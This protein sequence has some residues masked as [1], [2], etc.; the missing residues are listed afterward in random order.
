VSEL[1]TFEQLIESSAFVSETD[2]PFTYLVLS[3]D[4]A[5]DGPNTVELRG[6]GAIFV[7][8]EGA[9]RLYL[10]VK[11]NKEVRMRIHASNWGYFGGVSDYAKNAFDIDESR[12]LATNPFGSNASS[13][14]I[15]MRGGSM[16]GV[17]V[18]SKGDRGYWDKDGTTF[19]RETLQRNITQPNETWYDDGMFLSLTAPY[20]DH[21]DRAT[22]TLR[23]R[24]HTED[25]RVQIL[26]INDAPQQGFDEL[27]DWS[28]TDDELVF[29]DSEIGG[30][31]VTQEEFYSRSVYATGTDVDGRRWTVEIVR[32]RTTMNFQVMADGFIVPYQFETYNEAIPTAQAR[33]E[34]LR[35]REQQGGADGVGFELGLAAL[36][37]GLLVVF[38]ATR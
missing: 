14:D 18:G 7:N 11:P 35:Q 33:A 17:A 3:G 1:P 6:D 26:S 24:Q 4:T 15:T 21:P 29:D 38:V 16:L 31:N 2:N 19:Y 30:D 8:P 9:G 23:Y 10:I 22:Y 27:T 12:P 32:L 20:A 34:A 5:F 13:M 28:T 36:G 37:L 25:M